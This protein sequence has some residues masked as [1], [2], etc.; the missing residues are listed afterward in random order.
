MKRYFIYK[1]PLFGR[2]DKWKNPS[3][4]RSTKTGVR[5]DKS[6][7]YVW[8]MCL[9]RNK[10]YEHYCKTGKGDFKKI[11]ADISDALDQTAFMPLQKEFNK[12]IGYYYSQRKLTSILEKIDELSEQ[13]ELQFINHQIV[14]TL[15]EEGVEVKINIFEGKKIIIEKIN[16]AGNTVT[17]DSVIRGELLV[18]EGDPFSELLVNKSLN[19]IKGCLL[20]TSDAA[21]E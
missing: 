15:D 12:V 4:I 14:E 16:I 21:D 13:K 3:A 19:N 10:E 18:D 8:F 9:L 6:P 5:W 7:Y 1:H 2:G 20:Y 17:N 11:Y